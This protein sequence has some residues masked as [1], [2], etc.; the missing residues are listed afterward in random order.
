[1]SQP[2]MLT[3]ATNIGDSKP[4]IV[5]RVKYI[6]SYEK[7]SVL[8]KAK[9]VFMFLAMTL[10]VICQMPILSV[11]AGNTDNIY[12]FESD[13]VQYVDF[14]YF[15]EGFEGTFVLYDVETGLYTIHNRDMSITR[16]SPNSTYK[17]FSALM[18]LQEGVLDVGNTFR[19]W[20][21]TPSP[22]DTWNHGQDL[23]SAMNNSV[24]WYFQGFD[25]QVGMDRIGYHLSQLSYGNQNLSGSIMDFWMESS[26]RI[27]PLEQV[28]LLTSLYRNETP[29][30]TVH[31]DFV[32]DA[33]AL[34]ANDGVT[35]SGKTGT[36]L[37]NGRIANGWFIGL[38]ETTDGTFIFATFIRGE[39]K[40]G[41]MAAQ[42]TMAILES[43][44]LH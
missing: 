14:S 41:S 23:T 29:F 28:G 2:S 31:E 7:D 4:N 26:L 35:L 38:V 22:F 20:D 42:I 24:N 36:G 34:I 30:E 21:G 13:N 16:V 44:G 9:S 6:A 5:R 43:K 18:A 33:I 10:I 1:M 40:G 8:L 11:F 12:R 27:S 15:F 32:M 37:L 39:D 3:L 25:V 19:E 17:I